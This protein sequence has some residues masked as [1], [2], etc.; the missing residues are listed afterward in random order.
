MAPAEAS[1]HTARPGGACLRALCVAAAFGAPAALMLL[2]GVP[3]PHAPPA[4]RALSARMWE[5]PVEAETPRRH[6]RRNRG[7]RH[8]RGTHHS[9]AAGASDWRN[10]SA[11]GTTTTHVIPEGGSLAI[12]CADGTHV[13]AVDFAT[14]GTPDV[15]TNGSVGAGA[16]HSRHAHAIVARACAGQSHCCLPVSALNFPQDPC[17]GKVRTR[18]T[19]GRTRHARTHPPPT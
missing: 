7:G 19:L 5:R 8:Q 11:A 13:E 9:S 3:P 17:Y 1:A 2:H 16:C 12:E 4:G 15:F 10:P 14:Y 6:R 18:G